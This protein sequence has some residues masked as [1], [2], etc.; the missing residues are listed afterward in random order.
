MRRCL[1]C[2]HAYPGPGL[3]CPACGQEPP[4]QGGIPLFAPALAGGDGGYEDAHFAGLAGKEAGSFWFQA[5]NRLILAALRR[6]APG[7]ASFLELGCGTGFVLSGIARAFPQARLCGS[8][9]H[10]TGLGFAR[11]RLPGVELLQMDARA[12]PFAAEFDA[13]GAFDLL[14]HIQDDAGVLGQAHAAL[15]PG[16]LLLLSVPQHAWLWSPLDDSAH[17]VRRYG[18]AGLHAALKAAGF[19]VLRSTSFISALLPFMLASRLAAKRRG[20]AP[21]DGLPEVGLP[22][23]L[24]ACFAGVMRLETALIAMGVDL[25]L[26]GSRLV[27]ARK[28]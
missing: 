3:R 14:E 11:R 27:A 8:E 17:H 13:V 20:L 6:H 12:I 4:V 19:Q 25:P 26:G 15:K 23:W 7:C 1:A 5:R 2:A 24:N 10:A 16:G 22:R 21:A 28:A 18:K 9:L